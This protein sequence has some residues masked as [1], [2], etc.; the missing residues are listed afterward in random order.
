WNDDRKRFE[1]NYLRMEGYGVEHDELYAAFDKI[2]LA[3]GEVAPG[4]GA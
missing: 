3:T 4:G 1:N 2:T